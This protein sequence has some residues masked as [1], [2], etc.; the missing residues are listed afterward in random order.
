MLKRVTSGGAHL[1]GLAPGQHSSEETSLWWRA[2]GN[3]VP[4]C[5]AWESNP[6]PPAPI[7][8]MFLFLCA[9]MVVE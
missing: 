6:R 4:I 7:A 2:A 1:R 8:F 5:S 9:L 3:T